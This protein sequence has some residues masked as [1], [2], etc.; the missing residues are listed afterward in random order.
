MF[1]ILEFYAAL[2]RSYL[3]KLRD[4]ISLTSPKVMLSNKKVVMKRR[5]ISTNLY[6]LI[7]REEWRSHLHCG[8]NLKR[9]IFSPWPWHVISDQASI[10]TAG[11][12]IDFT[13]SVTLI[14]LISLIIYIYIT[15]R[16]FFLRQCATRRKV[17]GSIPDGVSGIFH[18][19]N[20][21]GRTMALSL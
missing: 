3:P 14:K 1:D 19:R 15:P 21:F 5:H 12:W 11:N 18:W 16:H 4:N 2:F 9:L 17:V 10:N 7:S 20:P 8:R 6:R 13:S